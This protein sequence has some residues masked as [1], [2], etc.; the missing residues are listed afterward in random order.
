MTLLEYHEWVMEKAYGGPRTQEK[1]RRLI[2]A[3]FQMRT[4]WTLGYSREEFATLTAAVKHHRSESTYLFSEVN[5]QASTSSRGQD[6]R[7][8]DRGHATRGKGGK[9]NQR[10][11]SPA[12]SRS[13]GR[14]QA[15]GQ[16]VKSE[17]FALQIKTS[18]GV[19]I[20]TYYNKR[21]GCSN[22]QCRKEHVCN[23]PGCTKRHPRCEHHPVQPPR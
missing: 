16:P 18:K 1:I 6:D 10:G 4:H 20:C 12:R 15:G 21:A 11:Q 8:G 14:P 3:D 9:G 23:F 22:K 2:D 5:N 13:R 17:P 7:G 19:E